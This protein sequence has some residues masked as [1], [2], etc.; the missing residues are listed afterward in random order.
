MTSREQVLEALRASDDYVSGEA[1][2]SSLSISRAAIWKHIEAL[3]REGYR[4]D[5]RRARGY[6]LEDEVELLE[7]EPLSAALEGRFGRQHLEVKRNTGSTN[8]DAMQLGRK[9]AGEGS[10]VLA[11]EQSAGRGRLGR[12]WESRP[13]RNLYL[14]VILRPE[15]LPSQAP[16]L[17]LMA[18]VAVASALESVGCPCGIKWPND[19][20]TV[21]LQDGEGL[22][23][24][25]LAGILAEIEAE[26]DRV[27]FVVL[28][29]GVNLNARLDE[30]P[31]ELRERAASALTVTGQAVDR[32][33][34]TV[35]LL[36][37]LEQR[38]DEFVRGGF[39]AL[40]EHWRS[41]TILA[42]RTVRV[43]GAGVPLEGR[44]VDIDD[45]GA[46]VIKDA[47]GELHKVLAGDVTLE[48]GYEG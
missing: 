6:R 31:E 46:L 16:Q 35:R 11:E 20:V 24:R 14:S 38:Y 8:L 23:L 32:V 28:G 37:E 18:G 34:F 22:R 42:G 30:F 5:G 2:A 12:S 39:G 10:V 26:A 47:S 25:K 33:A 17:A 27:A 13:G 15:I 3:K 9:G 44:C 19:V 48:G 40:A 43:S 7:R 4:I 36:A 29:I 45:E 21:E 41:R 1:L